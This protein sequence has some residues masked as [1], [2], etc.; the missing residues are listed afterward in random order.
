M[1][2]QGFKSNEEL[3]DLYRKTAWRFEAKNKKKGSSYDWFK[4]VRSLAI[5]E[6]AK[7]WWFTRNICLSM[8]WHFLKSFQISVAV[9][10]EMLICLC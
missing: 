8:K 1:A 5:D 4:Q 10:Y 3:E 6:P 7:G 9:D 2:T